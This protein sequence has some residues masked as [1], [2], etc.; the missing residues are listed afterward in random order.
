MVNSLNSR[1]VELT[2]M[3][4]EFDKKFGEID[5]K[6]LNPKDR[7]ALVKL[8]KQINKFRQQKKSMQDTLN[9]MKKFGATDII[10]GD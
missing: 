5:V 6:T 7:T 9:M 8:K 3:I 10:I 4:D 2:K 1:I